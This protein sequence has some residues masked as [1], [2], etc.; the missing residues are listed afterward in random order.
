MQRIAIS[1]SGVRVKQLAEHGSAD[2][3]GEK[4]KLESD[5]IFELS[6]RKKVQN[7]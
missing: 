4:C 6:R 2:G 1:T 7:R 5:R 3:K